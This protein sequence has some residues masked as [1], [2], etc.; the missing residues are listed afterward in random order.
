MILG[1]RGDLV[2]DFALAGTVEKILERLADLADLGVHE[3]SCAYL[4][5]QIDQM[6]R[7]GREII[8]RLPA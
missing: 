5:G 7:V 6:E 4:N 3:V 1:S 8:P 2:D